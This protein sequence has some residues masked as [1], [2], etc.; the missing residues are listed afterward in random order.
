MFDKVTK[1]EIYL[2]ENGIIDRADDR[3]VGVVFRHFF[4]KLF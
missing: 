4:Y 3:K 1:K 2:R